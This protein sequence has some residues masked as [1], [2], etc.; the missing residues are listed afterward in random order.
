MCLGFP[1]ALKHTNYVSVLN[2]N[3]PVSENVLIIVCIFIF[4][5]K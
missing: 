4:R 3:W 2:K 1:I 5:R